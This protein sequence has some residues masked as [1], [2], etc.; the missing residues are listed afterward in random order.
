MLNQFP[1]TFKDFY[2]LLLSPELQKLLFPVKV[3]FIVFFVIF[4]VIIVF[5][6][7]K[8]D[9]LER[10]FGDWARFGK[11]I[12]ALPKFQKER[13]KKWKKIKERLGTDIESEYKLAIIEASEF[14]DK[15]L[16]SLGYPEKTLQQKLEKLS[17][18]EVSNLAELFKAIQVY[19]DIIHDPN[20]KLS[21]E[22]TQLVI[23]VFEKSLLDLGAL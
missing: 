4:I 11:G 23:N 6:L 20:Y 9:F 13:A 16:K 10:Y 12:F 22:K 2:N 3:V 1:K 18:E 14:F 5:V 17:V 21:K 19:Y 8:T 15:I 7:S